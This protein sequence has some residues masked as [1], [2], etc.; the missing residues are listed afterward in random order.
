MRVLKSSTVNDLLHNLLV[1]DVQQIQ[2]ALWSA[3]RQTHLTPPRIVFGSAMFMPASVKLS[4]EVVTGI[5][6]VFVTDQGVNGTI[7]LYRPDGRV[8]AI[9]H[10][11]QVTGFRTA[12]GSLCSTNVA[13]KKEIKSVLV[14][15][16]GCQAYWHI[17]LHCMSYNSITSVTIRNRSAQRTAILV[18]QLAGQFPL[19]KFSGQDINAEVIQC[20]IILCCTPSTKPLFTAEYLS[21]T[22]I[23]L[24]GSY[25]KSMHEVGQDVLDAC[26]LLLG[27]NKAGIITEAGEFQD[28]KACDR[29][30][31]LGEYEKDDVTGNTL[32]KSVGFGAMDVAV[33]D[34]I[35]KIAVSTGVGDEIDV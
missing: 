27:D 15:G 29:L 12:L 24:I 34:A 31:E 4:E 28:P 5:K 13:V 6:T 33:A 8:T 25:K 21:Q 3:F 9:I 20:N 23:C 2:S 11:A 7:S 16:A 19:I 30:I 26:D 18:S 32:Y 14:Y 10:A 17:K 22:H 1:T 35:L